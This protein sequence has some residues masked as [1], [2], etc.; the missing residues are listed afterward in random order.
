MSKYDQLIDTTK[1]VIVRRNGGTPWKERITDFLIENK[2][3]AKITDVLK[4]TDPSPDPTCYR[5]RK[6]CLDSQ[7][8][9][10][11][12]DLNVIASYDGEYMILDGVRDPK[13]NKVHP[14]KYAVTPKAAK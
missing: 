8:T 5:M 10:M 13:T 12:Q 4:A 14:F 1:E 3:R 7:K 11:G 9:Y 6:H 2:G